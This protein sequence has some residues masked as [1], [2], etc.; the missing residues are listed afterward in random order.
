M[1]RGASA[2][3]TWNVEKDGT[4]RRG[5]PYGE[6]GKHVLDF[7]VQKEGERLSHI[8]PMEGKGFAKT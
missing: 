2:Y 8:F 3:T 6:E 5:L 4:R 1:L 7:R